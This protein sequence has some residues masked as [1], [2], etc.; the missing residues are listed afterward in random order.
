[1]RERVRSKLRMP[2]VVGL[3][4]QDAQIM[5]QAENFLPATVQFVESYEDLNTVV[6]QEPIKGQLVDTSAEVVIHVAKQ[7]YLKF[8][9]QIYQQDTALGNTF[10]KRYLWIFQ[11]VTTSV[12]D[13]LDHAHGYYDPRETPADFLPWLASWVALSLDI[14]WDDLKKRKLVRAAAEM[15]KY[16]GTKRAMIDI[17]EIFCDKAPRI[18]ENAWP[19]AGFCIGVTSSVGEDTIILPQ[20]NLDHCFMVYIPV[21]A[22]EITEEMVVKIHNIINLEKPAHTMYFLQFQTEEVRAAPQVFMQVGVSHLG[23]PDLRYDE[24]ETS[25]DS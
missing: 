10:L 9:P 20:I 19:Y 21:G 18:V 8:L 17:L 4:E 13:K 16:R 14:D 24:G 12:T 2:D 3:R 6:S 1:M 5:L 15:Y 23:V 22:D 25:E 11:H 7:S